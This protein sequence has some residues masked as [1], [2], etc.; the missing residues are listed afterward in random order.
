MAAEPIAAPAIAALPPID[1]GIFLV[2]IYLFDRPADA[3][4]AG[5]PVLSNTALYPNASGVLGR[6][7]LAVQVL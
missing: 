1:D 5:W 2:M 7:Y 4:N 3:S 6:R